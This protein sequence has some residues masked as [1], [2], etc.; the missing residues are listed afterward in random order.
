MTIVVRYSP[1]SLTT[2]KDDE[3]VQRLEAEACGPPTAATS[4]SASG[5]E[6]ISQGQRNLGLS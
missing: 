2:E 1:T 5:S 3:S 4:M 6:G